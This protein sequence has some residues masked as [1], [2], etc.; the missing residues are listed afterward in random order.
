[1]SKTEWFRRTT[2]S[3]ADRQDFNARLK[4]SRGASSKAEY[5]RIQAF[6][7]AEAGHHADAIELLDRLL[8]EFP[9]DIH[10]A[11]AHVQRAESFARLG[12]REAVIDEYR[13]AL[14]RERDFPNVRT[15]AWLDFGW[16]VF[17]K[18][19]TSLYR[20]VERVL[21]EFRGEGGLM[22]PALE[23]RYATLKALLADARG[24]KNQARVFAQQAL[25]EAA[26]DHSG[27][28]YHATIGLVGSERNTFANRLRA[29]AGS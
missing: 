11:Q 6:H 29:M 9:D 24:D 2:W 20:E 16:F 12:Q 14:Q 25:A 27:L 26:K 3:D 8:G 19:L 1:M 10:N 15:N 28:R 5:L 22:F 4:R 21:T 18:E 23:Y 13:A 7:L 17:E